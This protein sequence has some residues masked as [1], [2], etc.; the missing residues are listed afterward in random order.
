M[1]D[2]SRRVSQLATLLAKTAMLTI[3]PRP[4]SRCFVRRIGIAT[5][6]RLLIH[7]SR[8]EDSTKQLIDRAEVKGNG[9]GDKV[10]HRRYILAIPRAL[11]PERGRIPLRRLV[12][13]HVHNEST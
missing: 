6:G 4:P 10:R 7:K 5:V 13:R 1:A 11:D 2:T 3:P 12:G 8:P 9:D